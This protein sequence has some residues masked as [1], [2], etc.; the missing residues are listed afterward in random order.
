VD[1]E[2]L[3]V[4]AVRPGD[5]VGSAL[6]SF[7]FPKVP[8]PG[9]APPGDALGGCPRRRRSAWGEASAPRL[10]CDALDR[11]RPDAERAAYL[12]G[13]APADARWLDTGGILVWPSGLSR[14]P[15]WISALSGSFQ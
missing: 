3:L 8:P 13:P 6:S 12:S 7:H 14:R 9:V 5:D 11:A 2:A 4:V 1:V 15:D 10:V